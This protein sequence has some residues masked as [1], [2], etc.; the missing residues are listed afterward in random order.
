MSNDPIISITRPTASQTEAPKSNKPTLKTHTVELPS[1][2][3]FYNQSNPLSSGKVELFQVT[4]KHEDILSNSSYMK[5]GTVLD[6]FLKSIIATDGVSLDDLII[7]DKNALFIASRILAYGKDYEI[8]TKCKECGVESTFEVNLSDVKA[9]PYE[10]TKHTKGENKF[11]ITLPS[12]GKK[13]IIKLLTHKDENNI[14]GEIKALSKIG[15]TVTPEVTTRLKYAILSIDGEAD[16]CKIKKFVDNDL[17]SVDSLALRKFMRECMPDMDMHV[18]FTCPAC[19][20]V[21]RVYVPLTTSFFWP[22]TTE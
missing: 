3:F 4:A 18:D 10:F 21:D 20:H 11:Y 9:K 19:G 17:L 14:D 1:K 16:R 22:S 12:S 15:G 8:K 5:K 2:G 13:A 6:E 7:G